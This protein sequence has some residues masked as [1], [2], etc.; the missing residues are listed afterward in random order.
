MNAAGE[1]CE[2]APCCG[3]CG[4]NIYG[5]YQGDDV[6]MDSYYCDV[7]GFHHVGECEEED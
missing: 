7:C 4:T 2:D 1:I 3:C 5:V 6:S